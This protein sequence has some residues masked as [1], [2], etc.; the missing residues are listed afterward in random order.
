MNIPFEMRRTRRHLSGL[1]ITG[2]TSE[3]PKHILGAVKDMRGEY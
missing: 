1:T 3:R 2:W